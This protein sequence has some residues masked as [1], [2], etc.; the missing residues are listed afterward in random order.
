MP[1]ALGTCSGLPKL[2]LVCP[3][4]SRS[5]PPHQHP[6]DLGVPRVYLAVFIVCASA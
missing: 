3:Q 2:I 5:D 4:L 1:S 6:S